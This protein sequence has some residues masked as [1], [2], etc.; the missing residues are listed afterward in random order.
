MNDLTNILFNQILAYITHRKTSYKNNKFKISAALYKDDLEFPDALYSMPD[1]KDELQ[2]I[3]KNETLTSNLPI[4]IYVKK[5]I[6][7]SD[8]RLNYSTF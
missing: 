1:I 3:K 5:P 4:E 8:F 2:Y 7:E 6:M